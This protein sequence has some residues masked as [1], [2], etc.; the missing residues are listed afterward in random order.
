MLSITVPA[1]E[2]ESW[3]SKKEEFVY[4]KLGHDYELKLE[5]SLLSLHKWEQKWHKPFLSTEKTEDEAMDYIRCM[6]VNQKVPEEVY[7]RLT[8]KNIEEIY[9][10][11]NDPHTAT[12]FPKT[13]KNGRKRIVTAERIYGWM[14]SLNIPVEFEKWHLESLLSLIRVCESDNAPQK[15]HSQKEL[16]NRYAAINAANRK[17]Y[18][19]KG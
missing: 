19:S 2:E 6:S 12:I 16:I 1:Y 13:G 11:I 9:A 8:I 4:R 7:H 3:D 14:I 17:K 18:N 5:H 10:Y 15:K